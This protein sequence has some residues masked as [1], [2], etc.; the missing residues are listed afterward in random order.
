M[1]AAQVDHEAL[2]LAFGAEPLLDSHYYPCILAVKLHEP[3]S[4]ASH[5]HPFLDVFKD[6]LTGCFSALGILSAQ[7]AA[8]I[9]LNPCRL[10]VSVPVERRFDRVPRL[11]F[12]EQLSHSAFP[13]LVLSHGQYRSDFWLVMV[14]LC[15]FVEDALHQALVNRVHD[16]LTDDWPK[17]VTKVI[18][19]NTIAI[20]DFTNLDCRKHA[21]G[22]ELVINGLVVVVV[23]VG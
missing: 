18:I 16:T 3:L 1:S 10:Q 17:L 20:A 13:S 8:N 21:T 15:C 2:S 22:S 4:P 9:L 19:A 14:D 5:Q 7:F 12:D 6:H 23:R 11:I